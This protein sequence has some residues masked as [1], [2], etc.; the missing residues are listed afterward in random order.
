MQQI[1]FGAL[2]GL[3]A[4]MAMTAAMRRFSGWLGADHNYPLPPREIIEAVGAGPPDERRRA[5]TMLA[6]FAYGGL[7]GIVFTLP[8]FRRLGGT[9]YGVF[10]W[11]LSY[12]GWIPA[13]NVLK[14][15]QRHPAQR[16]LLMLAAHVVWGGA[17]ASGLGELERSADRIFADG[18]A[19]DAAGRESEES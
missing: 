14:G 6:H 16:N 5:T 17:L 19:H 3:S 15:A 18:P 8:P 12:L 13:A 4:T 11:A 1:I 2:A 9:F 10:V 7:A